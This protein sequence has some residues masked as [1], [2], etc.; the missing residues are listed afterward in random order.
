MKKSTLV[1][2]ALALAVTACSFQNA[3]EKEAQKITEAVMANNLAPVKDDVSAGVNITRVQVAEW[4][5]ELGQQGKLKSLKENPSCSPGVH[6]FDVV[7]EKH[8]YTERM[9]RDEK[10]KILKWSFHMVDPSAPTTAPK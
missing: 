1:A 3:D 2:L 4:S 7:F 10:G 6:C 8:N 9:Q 5:D